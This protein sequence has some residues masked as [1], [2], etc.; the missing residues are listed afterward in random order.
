MRGALEECGLAD[1]TAVIFVSDHGDMLGERGLWYKMSPREWSLRIPL[2]MRVP[3]LTGTGR[4]AAPVSQVDMLP[5]LLRIAA[6]ATGAAI[7]EPVDP[8]DGR[9]LVAL[10]AADDGSGAGRMVAEYLGEGTV[11]PLLAIR[12]GHWKY[13]CCPGDPEQLF[14][15]AHD[16]DER[17]NLAAEPAQAARIDGFRAQA[18]AHWD[19]DAVR[20]A[21]L[22]S[23]RRRR[24]LSGALREGSY[25]NWEWQP[26]RDATNQYTRSH[27]DVA[28]V[29]IESRWPRP[30]PFAPKWT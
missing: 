8:L 22:D 4:V 16:P 10:A 26:M 6:E 12:D 17:V 5:T 2:V 9:D 18:A 29:D 19:V 28:A 24:I 13:I 15:L 20:T 3:G 23:Q 1:D 14:D 7:P 21:V 27:L 30:K 11:Q 25:R